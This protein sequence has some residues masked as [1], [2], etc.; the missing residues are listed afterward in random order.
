MKIFR[1]LPAFRFEASLATWIYRIALNECL[2]QQRRR[3]IQQVPFETLLGSDE[4]PASAAADLQHAESERHEIVH[5][6]VMD[7]S[8]KLRA[9]VALRYIEEL[10]YE[11]IAEVLECSAGTVASRLNRALGQ[12]EKRLRPLRRLLVMRVG[13]Q[14]M[15]CWRFDLRRTFSRYL[16]GESDQSKVKRIEDHLLDCGDCRIRLARLRNGHRLAQ[17]LPRFTPERDQWNAI[18]AAISSAGPAIVRKAV[19]T[20]GWRGLVVKP[21]VAVAGIGLVALVAAVLIMADRRAVREEYTGTL[22]ADA[23]D[24]SEFHTVNIADI[25]RNQKPHVMTEGY[26]SEIRVNDEDGDLSFKLVEDLNSPGPFIVCEIID[27][28]KLKPPRVGSRV[29]VYGVSRYDGQDNHN[30]YEVHPVLNIEEVRH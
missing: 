10:S 27:S 7:L 4:E 1:G 23:L 8:P 17:E 5:R 6:A 19:R 21:G 26:V 11:Q 28:I 22:I 3:G 13:V 25:E 30:W 12:L 24:L 2:N 14:S 16:N 20:E 29:R 15:K 18:E 9:V